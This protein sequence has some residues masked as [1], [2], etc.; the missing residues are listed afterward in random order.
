MEISPQRIQIP[1]PACGSP[2]PA[3]VWR[4]VDVGQ[5]P[6]LKGQLLQGQ[7]NVTTCHQCARRTAVATPLAYHDPDKELF[8]FVLPTELGLSG[9][10]QDKSIGEMT[11]VLMSSLPAEKRKG[12]LFRPQTLFS[13]ASL[14]EEVLR[15]DG[16]TP[17][18]MQEQMDRNQLIQ[19]LLAQ[20]GDEA[21]LKALVE[22]KKGQ[23]DYEFFLVLTASIDG[24]KH[25]GNEVLADELSALRTKL[26]EL[27]GAPQRLPS[28]EIEPE[29][30]LEEFIDELLAHRDDADFK[31]WLAALRPLL[32]YQFFQALTGEIETA[33]GKGEEERAKELTGLRSRILGLMEELDQEAKEALERATTLLRQILESEDIRAAAEENLEQIDTTFLT[34]LE[35][36]IVAAREAGQ[37][38]VAEKL[39]ELRAH[40]VSLLEARLPP[41]MRLINQLLSTEGLEERQQLL[42]EQAELVDEDFLQLLKLVAEDLRRQG[43][44]TAADHLGESVK[45]VEANLQEAGGDEASTG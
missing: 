6:D 43:H 2:I 35:A 34:V 25:E 8:V 16:V 45:Q 38:E 42:Q 15:A 32:D 24:A 33:E 29:M 28:E 30:T 18:M 11:N 41:E 12:Y 36:N 40:V 26:L 23:L 19:E 27:I 20:R 7:L 3:E 14:R 44:E 9:E 10:E 39:T 17:E 21:G 37:E 5:K 1:C 13:M 31:A 4:I 22:E